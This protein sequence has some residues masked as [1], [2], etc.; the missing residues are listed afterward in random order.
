MAWGSREFKNSFIDEA[1]A[2]MGAYDAA[3][4]IT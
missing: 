4:T 1:P 2:E 3:E